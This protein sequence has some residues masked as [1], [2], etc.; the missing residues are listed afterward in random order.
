MFIVV[1]KMSPYVVYIKQSKPQTLWKAFTVKNVNI[2]VGG[3]RMTY[4]ESD[5]KGKGATTFIYT[6]KKNGAQNKKMYCH[7]KKHYLQID[8]SWRKHIFISPGPLNTTVPCSQSLTTERQERALLSLTKKHT[9]RLRLL[10]STSVLTGGEAAPFVHLGSTPYP[11][12]LGLEL[13]VP[14]SPPPAS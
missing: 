7:F 10:S 1:G 13:G 3:L 2:F 5:F 6:D 14:R 12:C 9:E 8:R 11:I 4:R